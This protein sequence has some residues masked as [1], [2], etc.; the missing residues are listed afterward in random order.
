[1][2]QAIKK[3]CTFTSRIIKE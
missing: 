2:L 3:L 1:M